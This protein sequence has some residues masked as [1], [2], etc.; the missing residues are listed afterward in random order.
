M[1][2]KKKATKS[3]GGAKNA[4]LIALYGFDLDTE[5]GQM[6]RRVIKELGFGLRTVAAEQLNNPVGYV[7]SLIGYR[8]ALQAF[9]DAAP[10]CEFLLMC[11]LSNKQMDDFLMALKV[12]GI[13]VDRK[14]VLTKFNRDWS[15]AQLIGEVNQEHQALAQGLAEQ[16]AGEEE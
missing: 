9:A 7:A 3:K 15:F 13:K 1:A 6:L 12:T 16:Q 4:P 2:T 10:A 5:R 11:N 14:A 8:P